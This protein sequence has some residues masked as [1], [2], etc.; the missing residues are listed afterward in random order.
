MSRASKEEMV[1]LAESCVRLVKASK[2]GSAAHL[3]RMPASSA[4]PSQTTRA[5][6]PDLPTSGEWVSGEPEKLRPMLPRVELSVILEWLVSS[7]LHDHDE[8]L[9]R[10]IARGLQRAMDKGGLA[11][12]SVVPAAGS[13]SSV[14][15]RLR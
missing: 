4:T 1:A 10:V 5:V 14:W 11:G 15:L 8:P 7:D 12:L 13:S 9:G 3:F 2:P 6:M